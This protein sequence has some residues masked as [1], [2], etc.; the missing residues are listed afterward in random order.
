[1]N[2]KNAFI[3]VVQSPKKM[4]IKKEFNNTNVMLAANNFW[5]EFGLIIRNFGKN[6]V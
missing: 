6:I 3:A 5:E 1:M 4:G 2:K